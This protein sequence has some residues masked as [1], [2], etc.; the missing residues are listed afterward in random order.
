MTEQIRFG[1]G[2]PWTR[3]VSWAAKWL[4]GYPDYCLAVIE[5][6][7]GRVR[8]YYQ[9]QAQTMP[10]FFPLAGPVHVIAVVS[11]A[12][13][14]EFVRPADQDQIE[15][16]EHWESPVLAD[17]SIVESPYHEAA[18][19][20]VAGIDPSFQLLYSRPTHEWNMGDLNT[21][22]HPPSGRETLWGRELADAASHDMTI[23][24]AVEEL[25]GRSLDRARLSE[26]RER[27]EQLEQNQNVQERGYLFQDLM[28]EILEA[29]G[30]KAETGRGHRGEQVDHFIYRPFWALME[31]RWRRERVEPS[32]IRDFAGKLA[33]RPSIVS[34]L[35]VSI[36]GFTDD[37]RR[38][39][40]EWPTGR[41]I[42]L[43]D[44]ADVRS[45]IAGD[46]H[47]VD[48]YSERIDELVRRYPS[49]T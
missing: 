17:R 12:R 41:A 18:A 37:A 35:Y 25:R 30:I 4:A 45:L 5:G 20:E 7:R 46:E 34:G 16:I 42:V 38:I 33:Y 10:E 11:L 15:I 19:R 28:G 13:I 24:E 32:D 47:L 23:H 21:P 44:E 1:E 22:F 29:H 27:L 14:W 3:S 48:L 43:L 2:S 49:Q 8:Q 9:R 39:A 40:S 26:L 31:C 6:Y 36:S